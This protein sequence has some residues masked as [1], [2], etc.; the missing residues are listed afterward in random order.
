M[1]VNEAF[2]TGYRGAHA[3]VKDEAFNASTEV[4][5]QEGVRRANNSTDPAA[6]IAGHNAGIAHAEFHRGKCAY[7][8]E[9]LESSFRFY[10]TKRNTGRA[11]VPYGVIGHVAAR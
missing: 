7:E 3:L 11:P 1:T 4:I 6:Y 8:A 10:E 9:H 5:Y 2:A